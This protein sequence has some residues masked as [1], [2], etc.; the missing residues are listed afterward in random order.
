MC[1]FVRMGKCVCVDMAKKWIQ[2]TNKRLVGSASIASLSQLVYLLPRYRC[3][4]KSSLNDER[5]SVTSSFVP[6][7]LLISH[8]QC[9]LATVSL[10]VLFLSLPPNTPHTPFS[11]EKPGRYVHQPRPREEAG[12]HLRVRHRQTHAEPDTGQLSPASRPH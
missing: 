8:L 4:G 12:H 7:E 1:V 5:V 2:P 6:P 11:A 3:Y 10:I 9:G